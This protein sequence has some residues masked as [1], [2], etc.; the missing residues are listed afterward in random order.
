MNAVA[1]SIHAALIEYTT[2]GKLLCPA[3]AVY[4][5]PNALRI[6]DAQYGTATPGC[7]IIW[8]LSAG[9]GD[10]HPSPDA[11][12]EQIAKRAAEKLLWQFFS[13]EVTHRPTKTT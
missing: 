7:K 12:L 8:D 4:L 13:P 11:T 3:P 2:H 1:K 6:G 9:F 5:P 10:W